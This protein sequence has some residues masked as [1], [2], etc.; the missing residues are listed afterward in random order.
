MAIDSTQLITQLKAFARANPLP[1][2]S[3]EVHGS[4]AEAQA[5]AAQANAYAGQTIKVLENGKYVPYILNGEPGAYELTKISS[6][7]EVVSKNCV[8][9]VDALPTSGQEQGVIYID[10]ELTGSIWNGSDWQVVFEQVIAVD[11][12]GNEVVLSPAEAIEGIDSRVDEIEETLKVLTDVGE[13]PGSIANQIFNATQE[14]NGTI[15]EIQGALDGKANAADVFT[16]SETQA[17]IAA[18]IESM[19]HLTRTIVEALPVENIDL[20]TIY[21]LLK[22]GADGEQRYDEYM[23]ISDS[24]EKIGDSAVDL[25]GY[26]TADEIAAEYLTKDEAA[27]FQ[28]A[29]QVE[30]IVSSKGYITSE[31]VSNTYAKKEDLPAMDDYDFVFGNELD[32]A[33]AAAKQEVLNSAAEDA[34]NKANAAAESAV[35]SAKEFTEAQVAGVNTKV[36]NLTTVVNGKVDESQVQNL[37]SE[38]VGEIPAGTSVKEYVDNAIGSGGTDAA[39]AIATAKQEAIEAA[40]EYTDEKVQELS[41]AVD[42]KIGDLG[43]AADVITYITNVINNSTLKIVEF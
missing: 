29:E 6:N 41:S 25:S 2:D 31:E 4:L 27:G 42:T 43:D 30:E 10:G 40:A 19:D 18:A 24:W 38:S 23:F 9:I 14:I 26:L 35:A 8:Q 37:I 22:E 5:Y 15:S 7:E 17:E 13:T 1:L 20:N 39:E 11:E 34:Q 36:E 32:E 33:I 3:T 21:M 12:D 28:T 16:K